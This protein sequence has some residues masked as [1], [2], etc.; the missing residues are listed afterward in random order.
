M[1]RAF[2]ESSQDF[3]HQSF[4]QS[5]TISISKCSSHIALSQ[6]REGA[7]PNFR[8]PK[9]RAIT[10]LMLAPRTSSL[11][12]DSCASTHR[13]FPKPPATSRLRIRDSFQPRF[14]C[15]LRIYTVK[16]FEPPNRTPCPDM[17][18]VTRHNLAR[19]DQLP[20]IA[21][22]SAMACAATFA[23]AS[24]YVTPSR[25]A[26][27]ATNAFCGAARGPDARFTFQSLFSVSS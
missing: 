5:L 18:T 1:M 7:I 2:P 9:Y 12:T 22:I 8:S 11:P 14:Q 17:P 4:S 25:L 3:S 13:L 21:P 19:C 24:S 20:V 16:P 15:D 6:A 23:M 10:A 26:S 27:S